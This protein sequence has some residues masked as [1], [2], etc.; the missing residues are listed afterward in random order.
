MIRKLENYKFELE[1]VFKS[2][3][4]QDFTDAVD[5]IDRL[6]SDVD[7]LIIKKEIAKQEMVNKND[8]DKFKLGTDGL[9][10]TDSYLFTKEIDISDIENTKIKEI[11]LRDKGTV[12]QYN[13]ENRNWF[14][15]EDDY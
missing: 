1:M 4:K 14:I 9:P 8:L 15:V 6:M 12:Y 5:R 10:D 7:Y 11:Y 2:L 3:A 13:F